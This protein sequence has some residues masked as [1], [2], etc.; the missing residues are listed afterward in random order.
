MCDKRKELEAE[1]ERFKN[2]SEA[3]EEYVRSLENKIEILIAESSKEIERQK[4]EQNI[5]ISVNDVLTH[6]RDA[7]IRVIEEL[8]AEVERLKEEVSWLK[9]RLV[10]D[11]EVPISQAQYNALKCGYNQKAYLI[12][13][14]RT[15]IAALVTALNDYYQA[16]LYHIEYL[17]PT[18]L[19]DPDEISPASRAVAEKWLKKEEE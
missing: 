15:Q 11:D 7:Y 17:K 14:Q 1:V 19:Y 10:V 3:R 4:R 13:Q 12:E 9:N 18:G 8:R 16:W 6:Q 2:E 5:I